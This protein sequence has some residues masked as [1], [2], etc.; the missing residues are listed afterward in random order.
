MERSNLRVPAV[1]RYLQ[2]VS[3][4]ICTVFTLVMTDQEERT[5]VSFVTLYVDIVAA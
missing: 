2:L 3:N 5:R 4:C 1:M